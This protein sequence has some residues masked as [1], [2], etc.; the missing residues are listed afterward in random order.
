MLA[1][2]AFASLAAI[3]LAGYRA[4]VRPLPLAIASQLLE[5]TDQTRHW[6]LWFGIPSHWQSPR[7]I[8]EFCT[9]ATNESTVA[10]NGTQGSND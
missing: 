1:V 5:S 7:E 6:E 8:P 2:L 4:P 3:P 10:V 9:V